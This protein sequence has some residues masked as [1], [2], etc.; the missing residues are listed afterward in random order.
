[1]N[2][3]FQLSLFQM[4]SMLLNV[5][6]FSLGFASVHPGMHIPGGTFIAIV[7]NERQC[8]DL[9]LMESGCLSV[10]YNIVQNACYFHG[11]PTT[12]DSLQ[13]FPEVTNYKKAPCVAGKFV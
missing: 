4:N 8:L 3:Y 6:S 11:M 1:M 2:T 9:C 10:D 13:P 12:C 7:R 5:C